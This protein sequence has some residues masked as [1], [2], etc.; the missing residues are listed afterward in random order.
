MTID[1]NNSSH[2]WQLNQ[3]VSLFERRPEL[4]TKAINQVLSEDKELR[5]SLIVEMYL[6]QEISLAKAAELLDLHML[7]ARK[8]FQFMGIPIHSGP[9]NLAEAEAEVNAINQWFTQTPS[10]NE[11]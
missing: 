10:D 4:L 3:I 9:E 7:E 8:Q 6:A 1:L 5:W 2:S 11:Q